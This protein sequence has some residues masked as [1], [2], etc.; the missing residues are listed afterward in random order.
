MLNLRSRE[1][2]LNA[3]A[4]RSLGLGTRSRDADRLHD[5]VVSAEFGDGPEPLG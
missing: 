1:A 3:D 4:V 2:A 5:P